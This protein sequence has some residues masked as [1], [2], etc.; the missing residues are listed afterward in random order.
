MK[1]PVKLNIFR[2]HSLKTRVTL[3]SLAIFLISIWLLAFYASRML[4]E[5]MQ[6]LVGEQQFSTASIVAAHVDD[7]LARRLAALE[8]VAR[9]IA[10]AMMRDPAAVQA[11]LDARLILPT[12][13]NNGV[14][15]A[16]LNGT[17]IADAPHLAGRMSLNFKERDYLIGALGEGKP[18]IGSPV[19]SKL[20]KAPSVVMAV[21]I[22]DAQGKVIGALAG[23]TDLE[24]PNFL[25]KITQGHYGKTGG[26]I[27]IAA[28]QRLIITATDKS[29]IMQPLAVPG[30]I[31]QTDR[32]IQGFEGY[33]LYVNPRGEEVLNA[34]KRVAAAQWNVAVTIPTAE[35]FAPIRAMQQRMLL[36][37]VFLTLLA[38]AL[39]WW[40]LRRQLAPMLATV[41]K[42]AA[43]SDAGAH[44]QPLP[45]VSQGEIGE[46]ISGFNRL[47]EIAAKR[48]DALSDSESRSRAIVE[49]SPVPLAM[50]DAQGNIT[51]LNN[52][53]V[54][55]LGYTLQDIPTLADWWPRAYPDPQY[56]QRVA[57]EWQQRLDE[58][59]RSGRPFAA[60]ET[61][62]RCKD[63]SVRTFL[64]S[65]A[66]VEKLFAG[67]H[68]V[69]LYDITE[70]RQAEQA[71]RNSKQQYDALASRI[72]VGIY[73]L[74][75]TPDGSF[76]LDYASP[77]MAEMLNLSVESL[78]AD[79]RSVFNAIHPDDRGAFVKLN[80][81]GIQQRMP[82]D[83]TGRIT[84]GGTIRWLQFTSS[85]DSQV[86]G[87][88]LWFGLV[89]D[90]TERKQ[91]EDQV[92]Q[93]AFYDELTKLPNR[94]LLNDRLSQT[95]AAIQ[96]SGRYG[97]MMFLDLDNFKL[98]NDTHGH[99]VGDRLLIEAAD[100]LKR[101]VRQMDTVARFG[102]DEFVVMISELDAEESASAAQAGVIAEKIR[103]ALARPYVF[104]IQHE[105]AAAITVEHQCTASIGVTLFGRHEARQEDILKRAD[106]AM[107]QAKAAGCNL[108]RF[109]DSKS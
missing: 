74:R 14:A 106:T 43:L 36:A 93:L 102:G 68:L 20:S 5:D 88:V 28:K 62:I 77:R 80:Q 38:G 101:Y 63:G 49:S 94:R 30:V 103:L 66:A 79:A 69:M 70:R 92:R 58:A 27:L 34:S 44:P 55:A 31:P 104:T 107:Y 95:M 46:L 33:A 25:D 87:T 81:E 60:M 78:L 21:P 72:P 53:F 52:A 4:R 51:F 40:M 13:F 108:I 45:V 9:T 2:R 59:K 86:D 42:L 37:T 3:F 61:N 23:V 89:V 26:Y 82:F 65:A 29:R 54:Q 73:L 100:R 97:A 105:D 91:M 84:S 83:W 12:L 56:R 24:K 8:I 109:C 6:R 19:V 50:N 98:L 57:D 71:L 90:V 47:L 7:E 67:V 16:D 41:K 75:S 48:E 17:V 64:S 32:F 11:M 18:T 35:A 85:P 76:S 39:T 15:V 1:I 96:R 22:R 10:P 99:E